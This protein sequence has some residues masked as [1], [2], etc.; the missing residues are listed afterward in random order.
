M[1]SLGLGLALLMAGPAMAQVT[2]LFNPDQLIE[3]E[4]RALK[5]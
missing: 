5:P 2:R 3:I 4:V 1:R